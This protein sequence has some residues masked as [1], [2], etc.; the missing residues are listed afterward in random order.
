MTTSTRLTG[1]Y[2]IV[3]RTHH[4]LLDF[5]GPLCAVFAGMP[6]PV[7]AEQFR[8]ALRGAGIELPPS[9]A[10]IADPLDVFRAI[11]NEEPEA[12]VLAQQHLTCLELRAVESAWPTPGADEL[13]TVARNAGRTVA[14]VSNNSGA[15]VGA[16]LR[17]HGLTQHVAAVIG[18]DNHDPHQMKPSPGRVSQAVNILGATGDECTLIG[19]SPSDVLAGHQA[20]V[21]VI[22]FANKPGKAD[23][24]TRA[25]ADT[26]T[27]ELSVITAALRAAPRQRCGP[28]RAALAQDAEPG[29]AGGG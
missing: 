10:G 28:N 22:G 27:T 17:A 20:G 9:V 8:A 7:V 13:L 5:D 18:R 15:A 3:A 19:D 6:A 24:L 4:L 23:K 26:V 16:Y 2:P 29:E 21:A 11:A 12:A 1:L 25:G 14:I